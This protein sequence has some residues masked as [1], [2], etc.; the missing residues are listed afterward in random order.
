MANK[1]F[2]FPSNSVV[3]DG[4]QMMTIPWGAWFQ[5]IHDICVAGQQSGA[6]ADR[7][8]SVLWIGRRFFDTTLGIP[9]WIKSVRPTVWVDATGAVV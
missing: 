9:I 5:R 2:D 1:G 3:V 6:T 4:K 7:P 8:V